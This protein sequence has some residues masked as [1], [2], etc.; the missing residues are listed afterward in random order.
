MASE[1]R[2]YSAFAKPLF[3]R[4]KDTTL[5][6][7]CEKINTKFNRKIFYI[8]ISKNYAR[9]N[10]G[11]LRGKSGILWLENTICSAKKFLFIEKRVIFV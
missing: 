1:H 11:I 8:P 6:W 7:N 10:S 2:L 4:C 5:F 3:H 9:V